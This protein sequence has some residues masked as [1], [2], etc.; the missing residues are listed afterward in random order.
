MSIKQAIA[1]AVSELDREMADMPL[2]GNCHKE[3]VD[4][5]NDYCV[6]C[7]VDAMMVSSEKPGFWIE[8]KK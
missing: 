1:T 4:S 8:M 2:C 5:Q 3:Y 7:I 6:D